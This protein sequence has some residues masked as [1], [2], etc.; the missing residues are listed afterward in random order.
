MC[1]KWCQNLATSLIT[2]QSHHKQVVATA[3]DQCCC[4]CLLKHIIEWFIGTGIFMYM[5]VMV[6]LFMCKRH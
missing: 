4:L 2:S 6:G 3:A 1:S 5:R